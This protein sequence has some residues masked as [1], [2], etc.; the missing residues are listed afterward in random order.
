MFRILFFLTFFDYQSKI[1]GEWKVNS[2]ALD[3]GVILTSGPTN[4]YCSQ[5]LC[6]FSL[7]KKEVNSVKNNKTMEMYNPP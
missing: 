1:T 7:K 6:S 5:G 4:V 3:F 2:I